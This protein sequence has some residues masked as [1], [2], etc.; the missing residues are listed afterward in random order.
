MPNYITTRTCALA[1]KALDDFQG[2]SASHTRSPSPD[3]Q[4]SRSLRASSST[5]VG[6]NG[7]TTAGTKRELRDQGGRRSKRRKMLPDPGGQLTTTPHGQVYS[8]GKPRC[9]RCFRD[10]RFRLSLFL[11][12][13]AHICRLFHRFLTGDE[14]RRTECSPL[15]GRLSFL[16]SSR[17]PTPEMNTWTREKPDLAII[18]RRQNPSLLAIADQLFTCP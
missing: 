9:L 16:P 7:S 12:V 17:L 8:D 3:P 5:D 14:Y 10:V 4:S 2:A 18:Y 15:C 11:D 13:D 1:D 6:V